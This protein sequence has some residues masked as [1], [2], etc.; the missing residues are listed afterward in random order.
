MT[1]ALILGVPRRMAE[2]S[3]LLANGEWRG[4]S[5]TNLLGSRI[6]G[7]KLGILGMGRIG[8]AVATRAQSFGLKI[9]YHNRRRLHFDNEKRVNAKY[10]DNL[11]EMLRN[12]DILTIHV[13]HTPS[14]FHL[15]NARR[16]NLLGSSAYIINTASGEIIDESAVTR[17]LRTNQLG[18]AGLDVYKNPNDINPRLKDLKNVLLLPHMGSATHESRVEM[19]EKV[20]INIKAFQ[21]GHRPPDQVLPSML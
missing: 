7:K 17:L 11:D 9:H 8:F 1:M 18:G 21:D 20:I 3:S 12:I 14:T 13:P 15:M 2:G 10:W 6:A 4:W 5:P 19:G 16:L